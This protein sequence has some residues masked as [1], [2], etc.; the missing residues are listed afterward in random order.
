MPE[1]G[2]HFACKLAQNFIPLCPADYV[3]RR[4][5][6]CLREQVCA[7]NRTGR[8]SVATSP[9]VEHLV[10]DSDICIRLQHTR[11]QMS[12]SKGPLVTL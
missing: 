1:C 4:R 11:E 8:V 2:M 3:R 9:A 7:Q 10:S 5:K 12:E 6:P